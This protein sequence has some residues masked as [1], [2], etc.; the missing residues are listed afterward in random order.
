MTSDPEIR[1]R[2]VN[3]SWRGQAIALGVDEAGEGPPVL[4]LPALS[5]IS[6]R[7][8]L[9][10]LMLGLA[11]WAHVIAP[12]WPGFGDQPKRPVAWTPDALS[13]FLEQ[14]V[15]DECPSPHATIG[16]G[17]AASYALHLDAQ[18]PGILGR[19]ALLAPTWRGPLLTMTGGDRPV[20]AGIRRAIGLP[21][22]GP[23]LYRVNVNPAVVRMMIAGHVYGD[24][25]TLTAGQIQ[26]QQQVIG[27]PGARFG[28][29]A[30][31]TGGLDRFRSREEFLD[32]ASRAGRPLLVAYGAE[33]PRKSRAEMDALA[34]LP[35]VQSFVAPRGKLGF[36]EE[37]A[38]D[39]LPVLNQFLFSGTAAPGGDR[40]LRDVPQV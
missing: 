26:Q 1:T 16:A 13:S 31:V 33:T 12:D 32:A 28:S 4:L 2:Q 20:F 25:R 3:W 30:F 39:L 11:R 5:S 40:E 21:V 29:A 22:I 27:A 6:T 19:L 38:G 14:F 7:R 10:P 15:R 37:F 35:A 8:E 9:H 36:H 18:S 34:S 17:H 23:L 24:A